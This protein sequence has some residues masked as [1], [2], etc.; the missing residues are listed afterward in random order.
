MQIHIRDIDTKDAAVWERLRRDLWP[1]GAADHAGEIQS[2]FESTLEE[3]VAVMVA[4]NPAGEIVAF[5]EL[6]IRG[7]VA[8]LE[9]QRVGY[10]EGLYVVPKA[11]HMGIARLLLRA[12]HE[13]ARRQQCAAFASDRAGRILVDKH[14]ECA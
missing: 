13:W 9:G 2:F 1:D 11:R 14:Y 3:P 4:E 10:V 5:S 7:D 6:S 8:G 12:A